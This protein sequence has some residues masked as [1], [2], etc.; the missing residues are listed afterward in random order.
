MDS[1]AQEPS[2]TIIE[3][4]SGPAG[5]FDPFATAKA[6]DIERPTRYVSSKTTGDG[7]GLRFIVT[8]S[9]QVPD[10][11][12]KEKGK[13][14]L[15]VGEIDGVVLESRAD[16]FTTGQEITITCGSM[17]LRQFYVEERPRIDDVVTLVLD[18]FD[19]DTAMWKWHV[20]R[21]TAGEGRQP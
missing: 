1:S 12:A 7:E 15:K 5:A 9:E 2:S 17:L 14:D 11:F 19:G 8:S 4:E 18:G 20:E 10:R 6:K 13:D 21:E 3:R 16:R